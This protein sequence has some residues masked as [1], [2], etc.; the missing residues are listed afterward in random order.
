MQAFFSRVSDFFE[1]TMKG[2]QFLKEENPKALIAI[3]NSLLILNVMYKELLIY[4]FILQ[5][6]NQ[7]YFIIQEF[8]SNMEFK[9][10]W[11]FESC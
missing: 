6:D 9:M 5:L 10:I 7:N 11:L 3:K 2:M 1:S 4:I 8:S